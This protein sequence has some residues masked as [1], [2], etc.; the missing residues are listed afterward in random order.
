MTSGPI[1]RE[2]RNEAV[3]RG[4][5][6]AH[7][8]SD[9]NFM[10]MEPFAEAHMDH[11]SVAFSSKFFE[12]YFPLGEVNPAMDDF[13]VSSIEQDSL[14]GDEPSTE[15]FDLG[16][17]DP[18][19]LDE[20]YAYMSIMLEIPTGLSVSLTPASLKSAAHLVESL[21]THAPADVLDA[22]QLTSMDTILSMQKDQKM[23]GR[24]SDFAIR[25]P[26]GNVRFI[27]S[28]NNSA[29]YTVQDF[30]D[31][32]EIEINAL[33][34]ANRAETVWGS[35]AL[36]LD[37]RKKRGSTHFQ[38]DFVR[39]SARNSTQ[40]SA[41]P[42]AAA[43]VQID[44]AVLSLGSRDLMYLDI[45]V[46]AAHGHVASES[47][48]Y[49]AGLFERTRALTAELGDTFS[50]AIAKPEQ[51][52]DFVVYQLMQEGQQIADPSF[53]IRPSAVLRS[54][55]HHLRK[56]DSWKMMSRLRQMWEKLPGS[57]K[58]DLQLRLVAKQFELPANAKERVLRVFERW[59]NWDL[60][61]A[62][63]A[64]LLRKMFPRPAT[65]K[66]NQSIAIPLLAVVRLREVQ[67][68]LDPG[69][70]QNA[71][72]TLDLTVRAE[73]HRD[74][75]K[76]QSEENGHDEDT[77]QTIVS[78]HCADAAMTLN[79][80]LCKLAENALKVYDE[81]RKRPK[82]IPAPSSSQTEVLATKKVQSY[83]DLHAVLVVGRGSVTLETINLYTSS[84][85]TNLKASALIAHGSHDGFDAFLLVGCDDV[86]CKV[87]SHSQALSKFQ[88]DGPSI[89]L[90]REAIGPLRSDS[91]TIKA[92]AS[93]RSL[94]L[95]VRQDPVV[96]LEVL[97]LLV[98]DEASHLYELKAQLPAPPAASSH[99]QVPT[100]D[101]VAAGSTR[102]LPGVRIN[103]AV[104][105]DEYTIRIPLLRSMAYKVSGTVA[106]AAM[107]ADHVQ[108]VMVDFD[109]KENSHEM[110][111]DVRNTPQTI[112]L[113]QIPPTNG[114]V[115][116]S[117]NGSKERLVTAFTHVELVQLDASAV[118]S[119]LSALNRPEIAHAVTDAQE[120]LKVVQTHLQA[121]TGRVE[122]VSS[123][124]G[125]LNKEV[126]GPA[127]AIHLTLTGLEIFG[128]TPLKSEDFPIAHTLF[129]VGGVHAEVTNR[130][131]Q[132]TALLKVP[133]VHLD[134]RHIHFGIKKGTEG[135]MHSCGNIA[136]GAQ[137]SA[138]PVFS[139]DGDVT[140]QRQGLNINS[141]SFQV[142]LSSD[143]VS[144]VL[145]ILG[146][147]GDKI[148][149]LDTSRELDY[150]KRLRQSRPRIAI[151]GQEEDEEADADLIDTL[152]SSVVYSMEIRN[153]QLAWLVHLR[154]GP[155]VPSSDDLIVSL[156][157]VELRTR[158]G[159]SAR[160][161]FES[162]QVQLAPQGHDSRQRS[163]NSAL[164]PEVVFNVAY[165]S[166][167]DAR[168]LAFQAKGQS[169]DL[170]LNS[171]FITPAAEVTD[172]IR[173]SVQ[174]AQQASAHWN[175]AVKFHS[176]EQDHRSSV[177]S[178]SDK[179]T[180]RRTRGFLSGSKRLESLLL[181]AAFDGAVVHMTGRQEV[182]AMS[183]T[184]RS[185]RFPA[186]PGRFNPVNAGEATI[187]SIGDGTVLY[188]PGLAWKIEYRDSGS[189]DP[190][191]Y[192][193]V[194]IDASSN[195]LYPAVVPLIMAMSSSVKEIVRDKSDSASIRSEDIAAKAKSSLEE[196][197]NILTRD[198]TAVLGR[199]KLNLGL[200]ICRQEFS[201]SCQPI[202]RVAATAS[203]EDVY[204]TVNTVR[205]A[206]QGS[207]FAVSGTFSKLQASVKHVYSRDSTGSFEVDSIVL[208]LL[209][210]KH[211]SG[212]SGVSAILKVSPT[213][214][215]V[216]VRQ[217]QDFLLFREIWFPDEVRHAS[218]TPIAPKLVSQSTQGSHLV[219]RYQQVAATAAFPWTATVAIAALE[220]NLD[221]GQSLGKSVFA[222]KEFWVS[223][224]KTSDWEQNL[225][226]GF[227]RIGVDSTGRMSGFVALQD[228][229]L[230]TLIQWP[231]REQALNETPMIQA[232]VGFTQ[233]RVK[234]AFDY[235]PFV[236]AD[237][238]SVEFLMY[239]VRRSL[240]GRGDRL[241]AIFDGDAV[242]VMGTTTSAA[243]AVAL[244]QAFQKLAQE[245]KANYAASLRE[246]EKFLKRRAT[247][248]DVTPRL[249]KAAAAAT[250]AAKAA[251]L[252]KNSSDDD[253]L[254][255][256][257]ISLDTDVV[258]TLKA[259]NL[260]FFPSSFSDH[261]VFKMEALD[262]NARFL[263]S[264]VKE[265]KR[266][267]ST[268]ALT[269]GQ[270][271]IGLASVRETRTTAPTS[272]PTNR[273]LP[274]ELSVEDVVNS[275]TG[276]R[277]G[278][279]LRVP[280]VSATMETWQSARSR[281]I[282]YIFRSA[283]EGK[284]EVGWNYSRISYIRGMW[285]NSSKALAQAYGRELPLTSSIRVTG[286]PE[287][288]KDDAK[289][290]SSER[291]NNTSKAAPP[292][293]AEKIT[294]EVN[295]PLSKYEY[296]ALE[297]PVIETP[298]LR[299]MGEATPPL[300]WIGL[301]RDRLPNLTHQIII[302][303]LLEL[304]GEVED[305]YERILGS[306]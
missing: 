129:W 247:E 273:A 256:S 116:S 254:A 199:L 249:S 163:A 160:L 107:S 26:H 117:V 225:C 271:R 50:T 145:D 134:L 234:V 7:S 19:L 241:V 158:Q 18:E 56:F 258:V 89:T 270:L 288:H 52:R 91:H 169:L 12:P 217:L 44:Q 29:S 283:F 301:H 74:L 223:S 173:Q 128:T 10:L 88:L 159:K 105:M 218:K 38:V 298:Q 77:Y 79:W 243:Q 70:R 154:P 299:D 276:A 180:V 260:G 296:H 62:S 58:S 137:I 262:A 104:F 135:A 102:L 255:K 226:L 131:K 112:S 149:D 216:N 282:D 95:S 28:F 246:I 60:D 238:T 103:V 236:V 188:S 153:I 198:P 55:P 235:Q 86:T 108:E 69:P 192:G 170:R 205:S 25:L 92:T 8:P 100:A 75:L 252:K 31:I 229:Q 45:D 193:E 268:L 167:R 287:P 1:P 209:N 250:E 59:R 202:A 304:A 237:I 124:S 27:H 197:S 39:L 49:L 46:A 97:D 5:S 82:Q 284:V 187:S 200:R 196:Q 278:T 64:I 257:P 239:N 96:L 156:K 275:S 87:R 148:K 146:F 2:S 306:S 286:V 215:Y 204:F 36:Q 140:K 213:K 171:A 54:A 164:L 206:D 98:R 51:A 221:L 195:I 109:I 277:G 94:A 230:R 30:R 297:P 118:Y 274:N 3:P 126:H 73:T 41:A 166:T 123:S 168:R 20:S 155:G 245:S 14:L 11:N 101:K 233:L 113:L 201:L 185:S 232:S 68:L 71:L 53:L 172:S 231:E 32:F 244:Y 67:L 161:L 186:V 177:P 144:T 210:S 294:A 115:T 224:K 83:R 285:A 291:S 114:R 300:E 174:N 132:R 22:L 162:V 194:K 40:S 261:Q 290:E 23:Q 16:E 122:D 207:F 121:L 43:T 211:V 15:D 212:T 181:D 222:I 78:I 42:Q 190:S 65:Q 242:Q 37:S 76:Q 178:A 6:V 125:L 21:Q 259:L 279:I 264:N 81:V 85:A 248:S 90:C 48:G 111:V 99:G 9:L 141:D 295:V 63:E 93:S 214:V 182:G 84:V 280:R 147:M 269:L 303:A 292:T 120:Q 176:A 136:F 203:F 35:D 305:A 139:V 184:A 228:F 266:L 119:L 17:I 183:N 33:A 191:L 110:L 150:L 175:D 263:A 151:N 157:R 251:L 302:V 293:P 189:E 220:I 265:S 143:T 47:I 72:T 127:Y 272:P 138:A 133:E 165:D 179:E 61:D 253:A 24:V 106:R 66:V 219:Q 130:S 34:I 289:S 267:H 4:T 80:E 142:N 152:L 208:S 281:H 13:A 57:A 240:D 227:E